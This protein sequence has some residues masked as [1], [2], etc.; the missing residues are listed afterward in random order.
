MKTSFPAGLAILAVAFGLP[1][2]A[3]ATPEEVAKKAQ[4]TIIPELDIKDMS[5]AD[6]LNIIS[7]ATGIR[8]FYTPAPAD[9]ARINLRN[10]RKNIPA[11][12]AFTLVTGLANLKYRFESDGVHVVAQTAEFGPLR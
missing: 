9:K 6:A 8:I 5:A 12:Q 3:R 4:E 2:I 1:L 11:T 10:P 7:K